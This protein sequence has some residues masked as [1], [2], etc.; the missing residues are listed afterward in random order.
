MSKNKPGRKPM[1]FVAL[2]THITP[3]QNSWLRA[4]AQK[5]GETV[6]GVLRGVLQAEILEPRREVRERESRRMESLGKF[7]EH[8]GERGCSKWQAKEAPIPD[9][10]HGYNIADTEF[11]NGGV[12]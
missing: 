11:H 9:N 5:R 10:D 6:A 7:I 4:E 12:K 8:V 2:N 3:E 1:G